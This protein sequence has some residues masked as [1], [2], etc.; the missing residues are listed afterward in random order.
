M[1]RIVWFNPP[2]TRRLPNVYTPMKLLCEK[3]TGQ[4]CESR[5]SPES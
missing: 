5:K 3:S 1:C 2:N 4:S